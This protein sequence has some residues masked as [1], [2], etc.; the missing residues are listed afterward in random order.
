MKCRFFSFHLKASLP[1]VLLLS[2][3]LLGVGCAPKVV[4]QSQPPSA[5][6]AQPPAPFSVSG[7]LLAQFDAWKGVPHRDGGSDRS[8]VDCSGLMQAV[9]R[10]GFHMDLPRTSRAQSMLGRSV[11]AVD[12][13]PG[14]LV[15]FQ[16]RA[17]D[18][19]GV[20]VGNGRFLH[21]SS[22]QGVIL[23][24]LDVYWLPR[25]RRVQRVLPESLTA[26]G[27]GS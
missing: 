22:S 27:A 5:T 10:D 6:P 17:G 3:V 1:G 8:G 12:M 20:F 14:D 13:R 2:L 24:P 15:Y 9:F 23:S 16:D 11:N 18:H 19:I 21:A 25:L 7:I 4:I 26:A